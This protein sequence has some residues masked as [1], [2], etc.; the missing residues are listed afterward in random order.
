[1]AV[2][3]AC[4]ALASCATPKARPGDTTPAQTLYGVEASYWVALR[5]AK[6]YAAL[7][8]C[9]TGLT[10]CKTPAT[11]D[12]IRR[13]DDYAWGSIQTAEAAVRLKSGDVAGAVGA[14]QTAVRAF[15]ALATSQKVH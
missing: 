5:V 4:L 3:A 14:A 15:A 1:L 12:S 10:L 9:T 13:A 8:D 7:P 2:S 6:D 11:L